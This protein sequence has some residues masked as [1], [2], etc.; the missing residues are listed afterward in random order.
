MNP[1]PT[2]HCRRCGD[3]HINGQRT[4]A[5]GGVRP[6]AWFENGFLQIDWR[7]PLAMIQCDFA[8][9]MKPKEKPA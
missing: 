8:K 1:N 3:Y 5:G 9:L 6:A 7:A 4:C 2:Y